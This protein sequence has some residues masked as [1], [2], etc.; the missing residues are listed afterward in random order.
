MMNWHAE[1]TLAQLTLRRY[2]GGE[3]DRAFAEHLPFDGVA[4]AEIRKG[5]AWVEGL[6]VN[7]PALTRQDRAQIE[8][9][10][11]EHGAIELHA[12]RHGRLIRRVR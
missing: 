1:L 10:L 12:D 9:L 5:R 2:S 8:S 3:A 11:R 4:R 7:G 6:L